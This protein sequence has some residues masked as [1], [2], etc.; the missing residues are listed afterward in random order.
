MTA[1]EQLDAKFEIRQE[2]AKRQM[3]NY[4]VGFIGTNGKAAQIFK[5]GRDDIMKERQSCF[6]RTL[7]AFTLYR[8]ANLSASLKRNNS[9]L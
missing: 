4:G 8:H 2:G 1:P 7:F 3:R 9:I 6:C 5:S